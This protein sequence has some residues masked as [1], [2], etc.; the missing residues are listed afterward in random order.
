MRVAAAW[1]VPLGFAMAACATAQQPLAEPFLL[2]HKPPER[3][4]PS[5]F[6][7]ASPSGVLDLSGACV[8][9]RHSPGYA[10]IVISSADASV[11]RDRVG[12]YL[13]YRDHRF[14]NGT[15]VKGGGGHLGNAL[16]AEPLDA[17]VPQ[18]C[19]AGPFLILVAIRPFDPTKVPPPKSPPPPPVR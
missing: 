13:R 2:R 7:E 16:P 10:P 3:G 18:A 11:G 4:G 12:P 1:L 6:P 14:R 8:R 15:W 5:V 19:S 9:L 17:R